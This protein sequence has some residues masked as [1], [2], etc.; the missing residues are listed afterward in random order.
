MKYAPD[1]EAEG[2]GDYSELDEFEEEATDS[3]SELDEY[4]DHECESCGEFDPEFDETEVMR[5]RRVPNRAF[6]T[7]QGMRRPRF[8][9]R[10]IRR[11]PGAIFSEPSICTCPAPHCPQHGSEYVRWVQSALN[12]IMNL[13]LS[14]TGIMNAAT[15]SALRSFQEKQGLPVDGVAGQ[16]TKDAL[17]GAKGG[18]SP[19]AGATKPAEPGMTE[20]PKPAATPP[21]PDMAE[22]TAP[23]AEFDF[24]WE[25]T[26]EPEI[27]TPAGAVNA[28]RMLARQIG[29]GCVRAGRVE[30]IDGVLRLLGL[31]AGASEQDLAKAVA[32]FQEQQLRRR[33]NGRLDVPVW[34]ALLRRGVLPARPGFKPKSWPVSF[35]ASNRASLK[36]PDRMPTFPLQRAA[37]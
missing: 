18:K 21:E 35:S 29:W 2:F 14:V 12:Q 36:R 19:E 7:R 24:E 16:E 30:P 8:R 28:N 25:G 31:R 33:G 5:G 17:L 34:E 3:F 32:R 10:V 11:R 1:L 27:T 13:R 37:A 22:P 9:P 26:L 23:A 4:S 20:P 15:R 6:R